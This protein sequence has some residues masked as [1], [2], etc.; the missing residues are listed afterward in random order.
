MRLV[1]EAPELAERF[2]EA[3]LLMQGNLQCLGDPPHMRTR[4]TA[5]QFLAEGRYFMLGSD[6]HNLAGWPIRLAGLENAIALVGE[7]EVWKLTCGD[8]PRTLIENA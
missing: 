1:Q 6:T 8:N 3:G 4:K 5:E 2:A 7:A